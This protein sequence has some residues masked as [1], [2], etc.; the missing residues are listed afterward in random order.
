MYLGALGDLRGEGA[1]FPLQLGRDPQRGVDL[2]SVQFAAGAYVLPAVSDGPQTPRE[3]HWVEGVGFPNVSTVGRN[4]LRTGGTNN[5]DLNVTKSG[6]AKSA[7]WRFVAR[8]S[9]IRSSFKC[10]R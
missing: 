2:G 10:R 1:P 4:T 7:V 3:V 9:I 6:L 8:R 5:F